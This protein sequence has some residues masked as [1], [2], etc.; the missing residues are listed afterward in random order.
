MDKLIK[1]NGIYTYN[2]IVFSLKKERNLTHTT[3]SVKF[4]RLLSG[5]NQTQDNK[6]LMTTLQVYMEQQTGLK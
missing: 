2:E 5:V 3:T 1:H 6:W 4:W